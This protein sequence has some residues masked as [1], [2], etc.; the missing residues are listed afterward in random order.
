MLEFISIS[1]ILFCIVASRDVVDCHGTWEAF[2]NDTVP[3]IEKYYLFSHLEL[4]VFVV[5][6]INDFLVLSNDDK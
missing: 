4:P 2:Y 5:D 6:D 3:V 1:R